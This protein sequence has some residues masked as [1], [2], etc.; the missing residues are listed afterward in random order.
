MDT[1]A[2]HSSSRPSRRFI[3]THD[4]VTGKSVY[5]NITEQNSRPI[6]SFGTDTHSYSTPVLPAQL[7]DDE[8]LK[9]FRDSTG[10]ASYTGQNIVIPGG[11]NLIVLDLIP[12]AVGYMHR[13]LSLDFSICI[14]GE[15]EHELDSGEKVRLLPGVCWKPLEHC[16]EELMVTVI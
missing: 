10:I 7:A 9:A 13:T 5:I 11:A 8:D 2:G 4:E 12:G 1:R 14:T 15:I 16:T 3:T 6:S